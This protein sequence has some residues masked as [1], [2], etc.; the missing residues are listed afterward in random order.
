MKKV[1]LVVLLLVS[2]FSVRAETV[3]CG[4]L[5]VNEVY[6]EGDRED[7]SPYS[8]RLIVNFASECFGKATAHMEM[9]NPIAHAFLAT[10]LAAKTRKIKVNIGVN[11]TRDI[12]STSN[13][14]GY[15][16]LMGAVN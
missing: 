11:T 15:I 6:A 13:Q 2:G 9:D 5:T 8:N 7:G 14:L 3:H 12:L 1:I 10:A 16:G 4:S